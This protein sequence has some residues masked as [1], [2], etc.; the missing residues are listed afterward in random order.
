MFKSSHRL[1]PLK[2]KKRQCQV[3][4]SMNLMGVP[5]NQ[6]RQGKKSIE[7]SLHVQFMWECPIMGYQLAIVIDKVK[8]SLTFGFGSTVPNL[9]FQT[10]PSQVELLTPI[11]S[12][13][14][15]QAGRMLHT[16]TANSVSF[17]CIIIPCN[18][19]AHKNIEKILSPFHSLCCQPGF[20]PLCV[21][22]PISC[23]MY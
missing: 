14:K 12:W 6:K 9:K 16:H 22:K 20:D 1:S 7:M 2:F 11:P 5:S 4:H 15:M 23:I 8:W 18:G 3:R 21:A 13:R 17:P 19:K 10:T